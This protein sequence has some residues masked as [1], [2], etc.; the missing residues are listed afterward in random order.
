MTKTANPISRP[1]PRIL[2]TL[3]WMGVIFLISARSTV[4]QPPGLTPAITSNLGHFSVYFV[5][6]ITVWWALG[7]FGPDGRRRWLL[8]FGLTVLYGLSDEWHQSF[9]PGRQPDVLD[10]MVDALG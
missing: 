3:G 8:A 2:A 4:P 7:G 10:V 1:M 6:A 5:L 9:V